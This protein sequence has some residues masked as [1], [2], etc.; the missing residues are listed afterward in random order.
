MPNY[1]SSIERLEYREAIFKER[2]YKF[3]CD[4]KVDSSYLCFKYESLLRNKWWDIKEGDVVL[5]AGA[6]FGSYSLPALSAGASRVVAWVPEGHEIFLKASAIAN[7]WQKKI[8]VCPWGLW[9]KPGYVVSPDGNDRPFYL[10]HF[11]RPESF[12]VSTIDDEVEEL[13]LERVDWL[14]IDTE[15]CEVEILLGTQQTISKF[16]PTILI[17]HH[18]FKDPE[19]KTKFDQ[20]LYTIVSSYKE[21]ATETY[22]KITYSL[23]KSDQRTP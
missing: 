23:Y 10:T 1:N 7:D 21:V 5:D 14:K 22:E 11:D 9:S 20:N 17:E 2:S 12:R 18:L 19:I 8:A 16:K 15:G 3:A 13:G 4:D 6:A